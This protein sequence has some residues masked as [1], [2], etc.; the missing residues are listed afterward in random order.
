M[1]RPFSA[2][3]EP[4]FQ[5]F[6]SDPTER[7]EPFRG[8]NDML[9]DFLGSKSTS[10]LGVR[11]DSLRPE[12]VCRTATLAVMVG[13][14]IFFGAATAATT[15]DTVGADPSL[16]TERNPLGTVVVTG[17]M[18]TVRNTIDR[19]VYSV[20]EDVQANFGTMADVLTAI[21]SV[22]IDASG[23]LALRGDPNVLVLV[24]GQPLAQLSGGSSSDALQQ[25]PAEDIERVEVLTNPPPQFRANGTAGVINIITRK[26]Q[27]P[28]LA[29]SARASIGNRGR[30]VIGATGDYHAGALNLSG[31]VNL[32][33][34]DKQRRTNSNSS[35]LTPVTNDVVLANSIVDEDIR[36]RLPLAKLSLGYA[37]NPSQSVELALSQGL[38]RGDH[39][40]N[41][42][43]TVSLVPGVPIEITNRTN[44]GRDTSTNSDQRLLFTQKF[45]RPGETL[46]LH[47][48]HSTSQPSQTNRFTKYFFLPA[49]APNF[50]ELDFNEDRRLEDLGIDYVLPFSAGR[51]LKAGYL[52]EQQNNH[53]GAVGTFIDPVTGEGTSSANKTDEFNYQQRVNAV[54]ATLQ[55]SAGKSTWLGGVRVERTNTRAKQTDGTPVVDRS[56][57]RI[58][59]SLHVDRPLSDE[60]TLSVSAGRRV[61][62]PTPSALD[63][64]IDRQEQHDLRV[65]NP[66]LLPQ[67][68]RSFEIGYSVDGKTAI[69]SATAYVQRN[70]NALTEVT[71]YL[72]ADVALTTKENLPTSNSAGLE[73]SVNGPITPTVSYVL[74]GNV[75]RSDID[76]T[77]LGTPGLRSTT[78][79]NGKA[80]F[81]YRPT[82]SDTLQFKLTRSD[83]R[84]TPQGYVGAV[85]LVSFAYKRKL[86]HNLN[87][88]VTVTDLFNGRVYRRSLATPTFTS[89][90][91][92]QTVGRQAYVGVLYSFGSGKK[93]KADTTTAEDDQ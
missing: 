65:G 70:R 6:R 78:G 52:V 3:I 90:Y 25:I 92:R 22:E 8:K 84:L 2:T 11:P 24:D 42:Y 16:P 62:W 36:R 45:A 23:A 68:T 77:S 39:S 12:Q 31:S 82:A 66:S 76:A 85:N 88:V 5:S 71:T 67:D 51:I 48:N 61:S 30:Y 87:A 1:Q 29:G 14:L 49:A 79:I 50:K 59:P 86:D 93:R 15:D 4:S 54:Y 43:H 55:A 60:A 53:Y 83:K 38:R 80:N 34:D 40:S 35:V 7:G 75:F 28:G 44:S 9:R 10:S 18:L 56:E 26:T 33:Q 91:R 73:F 27:S 17:R 72:L 46:G 20:S 47:L 58:Y 41:E 19:K 32:R 57:V 81:D 74:S 63:P 64:Y 37:F 13:A 69:Y 89:D 21:P